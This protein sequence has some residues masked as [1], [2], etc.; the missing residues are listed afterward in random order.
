MVGCSI[1]GRA[2]ISLLS[3]EEAIVGPSQLQLP[4]MAHTSRRYKRPLM[5]HDSLEDFAKIYPVF[6]WT[7]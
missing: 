5:T 4:L 3:G 1:S 6:V 7:L 2:A